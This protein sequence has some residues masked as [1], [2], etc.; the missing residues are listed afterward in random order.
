LPAT[1]TSKVAM[2]ILDWLNKN[3]FIA[4]L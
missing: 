4:V 3:G 2:P 1:R